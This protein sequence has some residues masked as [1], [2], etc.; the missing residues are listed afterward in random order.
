ML[1]MQFLL[2][3]CLGIVL[4]TTTAFLRNIR[5]FSLGM[6][7]L[8]L[9]MTRLHQ[10]FCWPLFFTVLSLSA[11]AQQN[12]V[13]Y[14]DNTTSTPIFGVGHD[15][16][17]DLD[18]IV[19]PANGAVSVRISAPVPLERGLNMPLYAYIYDTN[20][21]YQ[22][23]PSAPDGWSSNTNPP[24][25]TLFGVT[26]TGFGP[27][28]SG[29]SLLTG[30]VTGS[31]SST[32]L[33]TIGAPGTLSYV[34][35]SLDYVSP[36]ST[37][38]YTTGYVYTDSQGGRHALALGYTNPAE[39]TAT[40]CGAY[41]GGPNEAFATDGIVSGVIDTSGATG[42]AYIY[43][44]HGNQL[45]ADYKVED[46][47]GNYLNGSGRPYAGS[48]GGYG[49]T[50]LTVP[51][52]GKSYTYQ[53]PTPS[54]TR[55]P[56]SFNEVGAAGNTSLQ[57]PA[58]FNYLIYAPAGNTVI[59]LPNTQTYTIEYDPSYGLISK[60]IYPTG[61]TVTYQWMNN[62]KTQFIQYPDGCGYVYDW[63]AVQKRV[64]SYD[65]VNPAQEQDFL[66]QPSGQL[67][68]STTTVT[69][70]DLLRPGSPTSKT[71]Y[72]YLPTP[73]LGFTQQFGED[74]TVSPIPLEHTIA[75]YDTAGNVIKTVT[76]IW[77]SPFQQLQGECTTLPNGQTSGIFYQYAGNTQLRTDK[78]EYDYGA[79]TASCQ[80][81]SSTA[82]R[83]TVT[84]YQAFSN[85]PLVPGTAIIQDRPCS[86]ITYGNGAKLA[87]TDYL[88]DGGTTACGT[89]GAPSVTAVSPLA[90]NH[91]DQTMVHG[92]L[93]RVE[94]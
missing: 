43:D 55:L 19:N 37:C 21:Q 9:R 75:Y 91:D 84:S 5:N 56:L 70:K 23:S 66:Y 7:T 87:E 64:V 94:T 93:P 48:Y 72:T 89:A 59:T 34:G 1:V 52:L 38:H 62:P 12:P 22:L 30:A 27:T 41:G 16:I 88:Y 11:L 51:G 2:S 49:P 3:L 35:V 57:C 13:T 86:V 33:G 8:L 58:S 29:G 76:K 83:E 42:D 90:K 44:L 45:N 85:S 65:G 20:G 77:A 6:I 74:T 15:Y 79:V 32:G 73:T 25:R 68:N 60:I 40:G 78:A 26:V 63:P 4:R 81:P 24:S 92:Q 82:T 54:S 50:S 17:Q 69:T 31:G 71:V 47:N 46:S 61:A 14:I 28:A 18:E 53:Y 36:L 39:D 10:V 80:K 67:G